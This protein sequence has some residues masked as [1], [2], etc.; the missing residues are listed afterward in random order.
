[1]HLLTSPFTFLQIAV[2]AIAVAAFLLAVRFF[3]VSQRKLEG[4]LPE[5]QREAPPFDI[6]IDRNGFLVPA[7]RGKA[8][9]KREQRV[10]AET[11]GEIKELRNMVQL[12]QLELGRALRQL[13]SLQAGKEPEAGKDEIPE[14][15]AQYGIEE[16]GGDDFLIEELRS[17]IR[18]KEAELQ[19]LRQE[20]GLAQKLRIHFE[21]VQASRDALQEKVQ[22]MEQGAWQSAELTATVDALQQTVERLEETVYK[23]EEKIRELN[24]ENARLYELHSGAEEKVS[25]VVL[26]RQQLTKKVHFLEQINGDIQQMSDAARKLKTEARRVGELESMLDLITEERDALLKRKRV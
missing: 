21:E 12:Q 8:A 6:G 4:L 25:A 13:Q 18:T 2:F 14:Q 23:K 20:A 26:Q 24:A 16:S 17:Q 15:E 9:A 3:I 22:K 11:K 5:R 1:M 10:E 19:D 7:G